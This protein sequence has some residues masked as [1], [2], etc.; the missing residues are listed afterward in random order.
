MSTAAVARSYL[1]SFASADPDAVAAL[2]TQDF[3]NEHTA[4]LSSAA[5]VRMILVHRKA[6]HLTVYTIAHLINEFILCVKHCPSI[7]GDCPRND[8]FHTCEIFERVHVFQAKVI[9][10]DVQHYADITMIESKS[11]SNY[12]AAG[13][14]KNRNV[15]G[16]IFQHNLA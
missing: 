15:D 16:R 6:D 1:E 14:F 10:S 5:N 4:A 11:R 2:V 12:P 3:V 7:L 13:G 8:R 9:R